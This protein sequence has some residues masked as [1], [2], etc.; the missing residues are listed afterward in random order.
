MFGNTIAKV[1]REIVSAANYEKEFALTQIK[2]IL[3][4]R[5]DHI[6]APKN[7]RLKAERVERE[8]ASV[9]DRPAKTNARGRYA[10]HEVK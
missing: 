4:D 1:V 5:K 10:E 6:N 7:Q 9:R 3:K 2:F 8:R